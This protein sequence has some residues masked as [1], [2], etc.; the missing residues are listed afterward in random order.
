VCRDLK[1]PNVL[2]AY[3]ATESRVIAKVSDFDLS[4]KLAPNFA[5]RG[6]VGNPTWLAPGK[7]LIK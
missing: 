6:G 4:G 7:H 2:L 5:G 1:S 3:S